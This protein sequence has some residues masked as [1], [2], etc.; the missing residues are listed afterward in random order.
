TCVAFPVLSMLNDGF[1]HVY[2]IVDASGAWSD[3]EAQ[4]AM[5]RM[6][7]AGAQLHTVFALAAELQADW[8][9]ETASAMLTP[10]SNSL[11]EYGWVL[12]NFWN[13]AGE[14]PVVADPFGWTN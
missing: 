9:R 12:Q 14:T 7:A 4:A 13:S 2:P 3:Y 8:R 5:S 6:G 11:P 1:E 10:F